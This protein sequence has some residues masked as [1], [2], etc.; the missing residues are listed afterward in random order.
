MIGIE[1]VSMD[2][3]WNNPL[4]PG[5][6]V[7]M[8]G[9]MSQYEAYLYQ[10]GLTDQIFSLISPE[11][12]RITYAQ[13]LSN[14]VVSSSE[15][16][17][18]SVSYDSV[19]SSVAKA[20]DIKGVSTG[21]QDR[22]TEMLAKLSIDAN[23]LGHSITEATILD[24]HKELFEGVAPA[25]R[26]Q[27]VGEYRQGPVYI[28]NVSGSMKQD[29]IYEGVPYSR[30][31]DDMAALMD[32]IDGSSLAFPDIIRSAVSSA[33]FVSIHPFEDGNGRI[34][35]LIADAMMADK[36][37]NFKYCSISTA[38]LKHRKQ[39]Y[40]QLHGLQHSTS[41]DIT[42]FVS[43]Y[44]G[45]ATDSLRDVETACRQKIALSQFM[46][47]L[48]P[49]EYNSR[50]ISMMYRLA[51]GSFFGKLTSEKWC[52]LTKCQSATASRDLAHLVEKGIL[53]KSEEGGRSSSYRMNDSLFV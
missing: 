19:F 33:W 5:F 35:R 14:D 40:E 24:W 23:E 17:G 42:Q 18:I 53:I 41:M 49:S 47:T 34:S 28:M 50:E 37:S 26:P 20:L 22:Y 16:E 7:D 52:K 8:D 2:Y 4:W 44:L 29:V 27:H 3:V 32:W 48:D 38:L 36:D 13:T 6:V 1:G 30:I 46:A 12:R 11:Q 31:K 15:I 51:S 9:L 43:W 10:K 25:N 21:R 39:Y 45:L